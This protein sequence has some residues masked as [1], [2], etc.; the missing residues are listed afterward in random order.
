[1]D[2]KNLKEIKKTMCVQNE[3]ISRDR[4]YIKEPNRNSGGEKYNN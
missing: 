3:N 4:N 2:K 1:M